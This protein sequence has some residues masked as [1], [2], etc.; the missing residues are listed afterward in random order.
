MAATDTTTQT[1][2]LGRVIAAM[3]THKLGQ[4]VD[5]TALGVDYRSKISRG[6]WSISRVETRKR[7][8]ANL[9]R[10]VRI[11]LTMDPATLEQREGCKLFVLV[12]ET[13]GA[14]ISDS[15]NLDVLLADA[16]TYVHDRG[17]YARDIRCWN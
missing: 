2:E 14:I 9:E 7:D 11:E 3:R 16:L 13:D 5:F 1:S 10:G 8:G 17:T 15:N 12:D 6:A 4:R